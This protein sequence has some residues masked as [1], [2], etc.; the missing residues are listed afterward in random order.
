MIGS[1]LPL[2]ILG[3]VA[4]LMLGTLVLL[5]VLLRGQQRQARKAGYPSLAAYLRAAPRTDE[6]KRA[7][8]DLALKGMAICLLGLVF[9]PLV[10]VGLFPFFYGVRKVVYASM[11]LGLMDDGRQP[12]PPF[13]SA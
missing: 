2:V 1:A 11:G 12:Q 8:A 4:I 3:G 9:A 7:A 5:V 6:E 10:I 13:R